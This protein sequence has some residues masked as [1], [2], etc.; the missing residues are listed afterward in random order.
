MSA[1]RHIYERLEDE[2]DQRLVYHNLP[3][4]KD[5]SD[6]VE[7]LI[8]GMDLPRRDRI[9]LLL[10][11][12]YHDS[13]FLERYDNNEEIGARIAGESLS[14]Y[15]YYAPQIGEISN[16][17]LATKMPQNPQTD[18]QKILCDA[19]LANLGRR[20]FYIK[21]ELLRREL[22]AMDISN[23]PPRQW[24]E[25]ALRLLE[26]HQYWTQQARNLWQAG[27]ERHIAEIK[28]LLGR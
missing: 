21:T 26:G 9:S 8:K 10:A 28:E 3:H 6:S 1:R 18:L 25:G 2:L 7:I 19:D 24:Y 14:K 27:K 11:A 4:T 16:L 23:V 5:V 20:D 12:A 15:G 17:I 22:S 13:G